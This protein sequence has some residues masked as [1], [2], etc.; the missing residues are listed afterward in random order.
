MSGAIV[1][2][3][4]GQYDGFKDSVK[5][6]EKIAGWPVH[7]ISQFPVPCQNHYPITVC[8]KANAMLRD[9]QSRTGDNRWTY[10]MRWLLLKEFIELH[11]E[12]DW[13]IFCPDWDLLYMRPLSE[14]Y[15][16]FMQDDYTVSIHDEFPFPRTAAYCINQMGPL[17][18]F[19]E[20]VHRVIRDNSAQ[21]KTDDMAL[22]TQMQNENPFWKV[23]DLNV[24]HNGSVF[25]HNMHTGK[26]RF[27]MD[28]E[29]KKIEWIGNK[30]AFRHKDG[31]VRANSIH[32]WGSYKTRTAE[33]L[34][35]AGI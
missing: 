22:W 9:L 23:G 6:A 2:V 29:A 27:E 7:V 19:C 35:K 13:P 32:C 1:Y 18:S 34:R 21:Y 24:I 4:W 16:P 25:D 10:I 17:A 12:L 14:S 31:L 26:A 15:A 33:M 8:P 5:S 30:P 28:G 3:A 11:P 20:L